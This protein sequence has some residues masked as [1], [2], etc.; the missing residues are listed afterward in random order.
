MHVAKMTSKHP[1]GARSRSHAPPAFAVVGVVLV[2]LSLV[3]VWQ[4]DGLRSNALSILVVLDL[5]VLAG[6]AL[7]AVPY[8]RRSGE[9]R[10]LLGDGRGRFWRSPVWGCC[11]LSSSGI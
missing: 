6:L 4:N 2:V 10:T 9:L 5:A 3:T 8:R 1:A 7:I 11:F